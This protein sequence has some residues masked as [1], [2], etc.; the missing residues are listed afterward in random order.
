[1]SVEDKIDLKWSSRQRE[2]KRKKEEG[3]TKNERVLTRHY[4]CAL[5]CLAAFMTQPP[6]AEGPGERVRALIVADGESA[7]VAP[8]WWPDLSLKALRE[9]ETLDRRTLDK[10]HGVARKDLAGEDRTIYDLFEW[11]LNRRLE[12]FR[13]RCTGRHSGMMTGMLGSRESWERQ[14]RSRK[15]LKQ[16]SS[17]FLP[18]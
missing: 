4:S 11:R 10:L 16:T 17:P 3:R 6:R 18:T 9:R 12:Q 15:S 2:C 5:L 8:D 14:I 7:T 1:M 13:V